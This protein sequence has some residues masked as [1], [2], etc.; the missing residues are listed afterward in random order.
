M[1]TWVRFE[2]QFTGVASLLASA[3]LER[4]QSGIV[5]SGIPVV[6][7]R[8]LSDS[9][10][11]QLNKARGRR[12]RYWAEIVAGTAH[13]CRLRRRGYSSSSSNNNKTLICVEYRRVRIRR[14]QSQRR[15]VCR[16]ST[17]SMSGS[18][19]SHLC[20]GGLGC[21]GVSRLLWP[22]SRAGRPTYGAIL[23]AGTAE[24]RGNTR[25]PSMKHCIAAVSLE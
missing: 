4:R 14:L 12:G 24:P 1:Q 21:S 23:A 8:V 16:R 11:T 15:V 7:T 5:Q 20:R 6:Q 3:M 17:D 9:V 10:K 2:S 13:V 18:T 25:P 22:A 19:S